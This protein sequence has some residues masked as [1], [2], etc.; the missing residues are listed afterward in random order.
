MR[1]SAARPVIEERSKRRAMVPDPDVGRASDLVRRA[2]ELNDRA[3]YAA[4]AEATA[5]AIERDPADALARTVR[6]WALENLGAEHFDEARAAYEAAL[7]LDPSA[8]RPR[9]GLADLLRRTGRQEEA[10]RLYRAVVDDASERGESTSRS[11]EFRGWSLYRLDRLDE[12]I[13]TFRKALEHEGTWISV[14]FDLAL[15]LLA[16]GRANEAIEAYRAAVEAVRTQEPGRR[17]A[18]LVVACEDLEEAISSRPDVARR[19]QTSSA[20][21]L[22]RGE[23]EALGMPGA[24]P[25]D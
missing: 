18:P 24:L 9:T 15:T 1:G 13:E 10:E 4:A 11:L 23:L 20:R 16:K 21:D 19:P 17:R 5:L 7:A 12:A 14:L 6:A 25:E 2:S 3:E 22:L 8:L